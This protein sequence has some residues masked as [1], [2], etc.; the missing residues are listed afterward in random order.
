MIAVDIPETPLAAAAAE[1]RCRNVPYAVATVIRTFGATAAKPG[2]K[3]LLTA[4]GSV[5]EGWI[6][7]GCVRAALAEAAGRSVAAGQPELISISPEEFLQDKGVRAGQTVAGVRFAR[8]GCPSNGSL[9]IFI[10]PVLP[11]PELVVLGASPVAEELRALAPGFH[12]NLQQSTDAPFDALQPGQRRM[13]V[14]AT[15]GKDDAGQL[16]LAVDSEAEFRAFVGSQ[17]KFDVLSQ[18]LIAKGADAAILA[19]VEAPAGLMIGAATPQEI[20]L[21]IMA[22]L[23]QI[24]RLRQSSDVVADA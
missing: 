24:R 3:A 15:Q 9:D 11:Q 19:D 23:T 20:A 8:N 7:G 12:W 18:K 13:I 10:E 21:S 14:V 6:G 5:A 4:D 22:R 16:R 1:L 17:R 2:A